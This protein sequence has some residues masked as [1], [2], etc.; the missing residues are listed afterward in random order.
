MIAK[1]AKMIVTARRLRIGDVVPIPYCEVRQQS[2]ERSEAVAKE[3]L[4]RIFH[5]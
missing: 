3:A 1:V 4:K 5:T 2:S